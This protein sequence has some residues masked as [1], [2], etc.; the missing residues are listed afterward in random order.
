MD[1][2]PP[3]KET[4]LT[5]EAGDGPEDDLVLWHVPGGHRRLRRPKGRE[6]WTLLGRV[7]WPGEEA[8]AVVYWWHFLC[9]L[10]EATPEST[11]IG[12]S[13]TP[14]GDL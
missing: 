6:S 14:P 4:Y 3:I 11:W 12:W 9:R 5:R 2:L 1:T 8:V 7:P 13:L 10:V